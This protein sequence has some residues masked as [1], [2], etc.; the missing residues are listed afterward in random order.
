MGFRW[1]RRGG[2]G[3]ELIRLD[4]AGGEANAEDGEGGVQG[5]SEDV[6]AQG[7]G[8]DVVE[9]VGAW[10]DH[11][12]SILLCLCWLHAWEVYKLGHILKI[13]RAF[14]N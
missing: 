10:V 11:P 3:G 8:A 9:H 14:E 6:G 4:V 1:R 7:E 5:V 2:I 12:G 13:D